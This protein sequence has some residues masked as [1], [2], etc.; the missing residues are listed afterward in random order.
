M[1]HGA[2]GYLTMDL[3][4]VG[5]DE[6]PGNPQRDPGYVY[7]QSGRMDGHPAIMVQVQRR[8]LPDPYPRTLTV[9]ISPTP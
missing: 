8:L 1:V 7:Y 9:R 5:T 4:A 2:S 6:Q 3:D